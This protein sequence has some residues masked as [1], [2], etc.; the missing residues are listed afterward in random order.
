LVAG[1]LFFREENLLYVGKDNPGLLDRWTRSLDTLH[2]TYLL[3]KAIMHTH[4]HVHILR[5]IKWAILVNK[6]AMNPCAIYCQY[7]LRAKPF[8]P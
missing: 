7:V 2:M 1:T 8:D 4:I 6:N 3:D 5:Q